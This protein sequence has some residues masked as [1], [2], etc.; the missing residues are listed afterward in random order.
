VVL[1]NEWL[2]HNQTNL[3]HN[4]VNDYLARLRH[5]YQKRQEAVKALKLKKQEKI[6][7]EAEKLKRREEKNDERF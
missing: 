1:T 6:L 3:K 5:S 4:L 7:Q 2:S